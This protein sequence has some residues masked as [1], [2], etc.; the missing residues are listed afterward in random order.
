MTDVSPNTKGT[1]FHQVVINVHVVNWAHTSA[2][3]IF[4]PED[5]GCSSEIRVPTDP[6]LNS[7]HQQWPVPIPTNTLPYKDKW[8][9]EKRHSYI[10]PTTYHWLPLSLH[11]SIHWGVRQTSWSHIVHSTSHIIWADIKSIK[12]HQITL[13]YIQLSPKPMYLG[14]PK[15]HTENPQWITV[16]Y[17][18]LV[19]PKE[20][21]ALA[22]AWKQISS[23]VGEAF[24]G[25]ALWRWEGTSNSETYQILNQIF[26]STQIFG[27]NIWLP[28]VIRVIEGKR[29]KTPMVLENFGI[30]SG[31]GILWFTTSYAILF[32]QWHKVSIVRASM[33]CKN[34][35]YLPGNE[36]IFP[37]K[38]EVWK[39]IESSWCRKRDREYVSYHEGN[40]TFSQ[41]TKNKATLWKIASYWCY[42]WLS[43]PFLDFTDLFWLGQLWSK[44]YTQIIL[45]GCNPD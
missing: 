40:E 32:C 37:T 23:N 31:S 14:S 16:F 24:F 38:R 7:E 34:N 11:T 1:I 29:G 20:T 4:L 19:V 43:S 18:H 6:L 26:F 22:S 2:T 8:W 25:E 35:L 5:A 28:K 9:I 15:I 44:R 42:R 33:L 27:P 30:I 10:T 36:S 39:I 21:L 17:P 12:H 41:M 45:G 13:K 3:M